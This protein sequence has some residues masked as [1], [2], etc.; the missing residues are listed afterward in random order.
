MYQAP[1]QYPTAPMQVPTPPLAT[2][3]IR[4]LS[5]Q[6]LNFKATIS[7]PSLI[8]NFPYKHVGK[9]DGHEVF[10]TAASIP[11]GI[12]LEQWKL[13]VARMKEISIKENV[14]RQKVLETVYTDPFLPYG[15]RSDYQYKIHGR[16]FNGRPEKRPNTRDQYAHNQWLQEKLATIPECDGEFITN[17]IH[18]LMVEIVQSLSQVCPD[19]V[20]TYNYYPFK[21]EGN[22][23]DKFEIVMF[24]RP[25]QQIPAAQAVCDMS[26]QFAQATPV[27]LHMMYPSAPQSYY[28]P[29]TIRS[30]ISGSTSSHFDPTTR[31]TSSTTI[32]S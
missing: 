21:M 11:E 5:N 23:V 20:F 24:R 29:T 32:S 15:T 30:A 16:M 27:P 18:T 17:E 6:V 3:G 22:R 10:S 25:P 13:V 31:C 12:P 14:K 9:T 26:E 7:N 2:F 19:Y 1:Q 28:S 4:R 8:Q